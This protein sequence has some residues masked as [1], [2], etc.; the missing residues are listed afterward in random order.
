MRPR[1][2]LT[3]ALFL[4]VLISVGIVSGEGYGQECSVTIPLR[5]LDHH[6]QRITNI[7]PDQLR[8]EVDGSPVNVSSI[9]AVP[10]TGVVL[11]LDVSPSMGKTWKQSIMAARQLVEKVGDKL[12]LFAF[13]V[14]ISGYA[15][16]RSKSE[17]LL[18]RFLQQGAPKPPGG[19]ALYDV[20]IEVAQRITARDSAIVVISDGGDNASHR[21]SDQ[22]ASLFISSSW[23]PVFALIVDYDEIDRRRGYF[24]KIPA[25]TGGTIVYPTSASKV[26]PA[27]DELAGIVL[28]PYAITLQLPHPPK[29]PAKLKVEVMR[30]D[31]KPNKDVQVLHVTALGACDA[32][33]P[34]QH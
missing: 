3:R 8:A 16:G 14:G 6:G 17:E 23:P 20:L 10:K 30:A 21:S 12:T 34:S 1:Y 2:C 4:A 25:A 9:E 13:D 7:T 31:G 18:D 15:I 29:D 26:E 28:N 33:R 11:L 22:A 27:A 5:L 32:A 24:K 19:T